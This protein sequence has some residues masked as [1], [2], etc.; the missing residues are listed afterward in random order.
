MNRAEQLVG[1]S[2]PNGWF[3]GRQFEDDLVLFVRSAFKHLRPND[4]WQLARSLFAYTTCH[5]AMS[6]IFRSEFHRIKE[7]SDP[8]EVDAVLTTESLVEASDLVVQSFQNMSPETFLTS[9][10]P[11]SILFAWKEAKS[12]SAPREFLSRIT[13]SNEKFIA[14]LEALLSLSSTAQNGIPRLV[15]NSLKPFLDIEE[16]QRRLTRIAVADNAQ[17]KRARELNN[18]WWM[19]RESPQSR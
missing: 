8:F 6:V 15:E 4:R 10:D 5:W 1:H 14:T 2:L 3:E 11:I 17:S 7:K 18:L 13:T 19:E 16:T 9:Y 12:E